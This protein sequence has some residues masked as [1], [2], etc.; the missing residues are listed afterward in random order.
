MNKYRNSQI[1]TKTFFPII[2]EKITNFLQGKNLAC[3]MMSPR[4]EEGCVRSGHVT[5][6]KVTSR[7]G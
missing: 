2:R 5:G 4:E 3:A 7:K 6:Q 1:Y